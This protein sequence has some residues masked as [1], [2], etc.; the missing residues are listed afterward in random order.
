MPSGQNEARSSKSGR[1][2]GLLSSAG[3]DV[4]AA[5][6]L[7]LG[8]ALWLHGACLRQAIRQQDPALE[9]HF[10]QILGEDQSSVCARRI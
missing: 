1:G 5:P 2:V 8:V 7:L 10:C 4:H 9:L 3:L 6:A